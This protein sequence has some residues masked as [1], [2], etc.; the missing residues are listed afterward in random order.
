MSR[1]SWQVRVMVA[2]VGVAVA[3]G[4]LLAA[5]RIG[6]AWLLIIS[7][8]GVAILAVG[9]LMSLGFMHTTLRK[10]IDEPPNDYQRG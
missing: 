7:L 2:I 1:E 8:V 4:G 5:I 3:A 9:N 6:N 10:H